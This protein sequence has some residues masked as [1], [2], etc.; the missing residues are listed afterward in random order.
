MNNYYY[1]YYYYYSNITS[2]DWILLEKLTVAQ[3]LKNFSTS[4]WNQ[5]VHYSVHKSLHLVPVLS[6]INLVQNLIL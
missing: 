3:L 4:L 5:N 2:R 1:Y 6:L